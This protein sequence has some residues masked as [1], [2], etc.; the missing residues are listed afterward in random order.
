MKSKD[1]KF[2]LCISSISL[3]AIVAFYFGWLKLFY[4]VASISALLYFISVV[5]YL[6]YSDTYLQ[7]LYYILCFII[8]VEIGYLLSG[9]Q[10]SGVLLGC[11]FATIIGLIEY[12]YKNRKGDS[13]ID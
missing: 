4:F 2:G 8:Y 12:V 1:I 10:F 5:L 6:V 3:W 9:A 13:K 7:R 11:C